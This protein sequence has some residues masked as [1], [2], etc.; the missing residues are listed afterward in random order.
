M[1]VYFISSFYVLLRISSSVRY[2]SSTRGA[3][4]FSVEY[5]FKV[6]QALVM[7]L[8]L[9][10]R[11]CLRRYHS[12]K[13]LH[14]HDYFSTRYSYFHKIQFMLSP[15]SWQHAFLV[16]TCIRRFLVIHYGTH[17]VRT[18]V[19]DRW[20]GWINIRRTGLLPGWSRCV[21]IILVYANVLVT[22]AHRRKISILPCSNF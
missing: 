4:K 15:S 17:I 22:G 16:P 11:W 10:S 14:G 1:R 21:E 8:S 5:L 13:R 6:I 7:S 12:R 2:M 18:T 20:T 3:Q 19:A 9:W